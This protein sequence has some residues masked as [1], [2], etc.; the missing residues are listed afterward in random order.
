MGRNFCGM[1]Y[2]LNKQGPGRWLIVDEANNEAGS[3][4]LS[5]IKK[6]N[7]FNYHLRTQYIGDVDHRDFAL[8]LWAANRIIE[9]GG[10]ETI[11]RITKKEVEMT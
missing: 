8:R 6:W 3:A 2:T 1:K 7:V 9:S 4:W 10:K 5:P 11:K